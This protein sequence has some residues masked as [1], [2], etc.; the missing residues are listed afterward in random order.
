M[1]KQTRVKT[2]GLF[3]QSRHSIGLS[4]SQD[5]SVQAMT[6]VAL[7]LSMAFFAILIV[8]LISM[9]VKQD[10]PDENQ[11]ISVVDSSVN[12]DNTSKPNDKSSQENAQQTSYIFYYQ[13]KFYNQS[14]SLIDPKTLQNDSEYVLAFAPN[15]QLNQTI[16]VQQQFENF[17]IKV[18]QMNEEWLSAFENRVN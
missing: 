5:S 4:V 15:T 9:G 3:M 11:N 8:A 16:E 6:E 7:G 17:S 1:H 12:S 14:L 10:S 18:T 13:S 2:K